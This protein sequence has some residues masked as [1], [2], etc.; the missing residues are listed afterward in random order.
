MSDLTKHRDLQCVKPAITIN[1]EVEHKRADMFLIVTFQY[2]MLNV[3]LYVRSMQPI[4]SVQKGPPCAKTCTLD[5]S[6]LLK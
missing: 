6:S 5:K 3:I 1:L 2:W 4:C